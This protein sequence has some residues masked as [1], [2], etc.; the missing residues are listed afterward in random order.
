MEYQAPLM[1]RARL[2]GALSLD[3]ETLEELEGLGLL[4]QPAGRADDGE[5]LFHPGVLLVIDCVL[6]ARDA[7]MELPTVQRLLAVYELLGT[8]ADCW[9]DRALISALAVQAELRRQPEGS[10]AFDGGIRRPVRAIAAV[11]QGGRARVVRH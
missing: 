7:G 10:A 11:D 9:G 4:P 8:S 5:P 2:A 3:L 6:R 1:T